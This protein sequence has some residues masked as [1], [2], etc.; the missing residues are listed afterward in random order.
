MADKRDYYET[1]GISKGASDDDIKKAYRK[2]AKKHHP[3]V[4]PDNKEAEDKFKQVSEAY[5]ILSDPQKKAAYDQYG[6]SAFDSGA[7]GY[8]YSGGFDS[9]DIF[10]TIFGGGFGDIFGNGGGSRRRNAPRRGADV[11][12]NMQI[13][14]EESIFGVNKNV[15]ISINETC[16]TCKG[17]GAKPGTFAESCKRCNGTGQERVV[18]QTV[19]GTI[20]NSVPCSACKG[21]GKII[22]DRCQT[23]SG[24]GKVKKSKTLEIAIPKGI[25]NGQSIRLTG[26]GEPG[27]KGGPNGDL[28][29]TIYV[30]PS[31]LYT[32]KKDNL[33]LE[34]PI[35]FVQATLGCEITIPTLY[36]EEKQTI[37]AG[38]QTG[39]IISLRSKGA[40]QV[41]TR[42]IGDLIVTLKVTV[43]TTLTDK[44]RQIL[45]DFAEEMG[46]DYK[47]H[48]KGFFDKLKK[49]FK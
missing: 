1:L 36:G 2:Q 46:E 26:K 40:P 47:D 10:E 33:Y 42:I 21:E 22:K 48:K 14:F 7:G 12:A 45:I 18:Q 3:D 38:T 24:Q 16:D 43:P 15:T 49:G 31:K 30:K 9:S 32:R 37:K 17:T 20:A 5:E 34:V 13:E 27:E 6:H 23:C 8:S 35:T 19:F 29:I 28:L 4:N 11:H 44:Q 41:N 25:D 39:T